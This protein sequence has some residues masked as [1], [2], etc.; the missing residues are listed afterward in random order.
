VDR[1][2][3]SKPRKIKYALEV[4]LTITRGQRAGKIDVPC[5]IS[6]MNFHINFP[7]GIRY[8][9]GDDRKEDETKKGG[10]WSC[11]AIQVVLPDIADA[12]LEIPISFGFDRNPTTV[13]PWLPTI[14][15]LTM[16]LAL[17]SWLSLVSLD[18]LLKLV[19]AALAALPGTYLMLYIRAYQRSRAF[20]KAYTIKK[21]PNRG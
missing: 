1:W 3:Q 15:A 14:F 2:L 8:I 10:F 11:P 9:Y 20:F 16:T 18:L 17:F 4:P 21:M 13:L 5:T 19:G 7:E 6:A 12:D